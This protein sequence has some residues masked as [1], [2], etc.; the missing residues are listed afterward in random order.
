MKNTPW[1]G[2]HLDKMAAAFIAAFVP[3]ETRIE[4]TYRGWRVIATDH[5][6][7]GIKAGKQ[8]EID[9]FADFEAALRA[10]KHEINRREGEQVWDENYTNEALR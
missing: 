7:I 5:A 1:L 8:F 3:K 6:V 10:G 9:Q 2:P 4:A